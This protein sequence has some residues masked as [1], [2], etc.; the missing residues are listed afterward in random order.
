VLEALTRLCNKA[1]ESSLVLSLMAKPVDASMPSRVNVCLSA[2]ISA[3]LLRSDVLAVDDASFDGG[4]SGGGG[5]VTDVF[6][7]IGSGDMG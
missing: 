4:G 6:V 2:V 3:S 7:L 5:V 1:S